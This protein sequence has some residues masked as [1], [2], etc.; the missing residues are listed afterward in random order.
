MEDRTLK[1]VDGMCGQLHQISAFGQERRLPRIRLL[2]V[3]LVIPICMVVVFAD[4]FFFGSAIRKSW[5]HFPVTGQRWWLLLFGLPHLIAGNMTML[6]REYLTYYRDKLLPAVVAYGGVS[7]AGAYGPAWLSNLVIIILSFYTVFHLLA[8]QAGLGL[9]MLARVERNAQVWRQL[10][11][12]GGLILFLVVY[13]HI[14]WPQ[15]SVASYN[16]VAIGMMIF[17]VLICALTVVTAKIQSA[18]IDLVACSYLWA[19]VVM[20]FAVVLFFSFGYVAI[21]FIIPR[22]IHD[23]TAYQIYFNHD[24][25]RNRSARHHLLYVSRYLSFFPFSVTLILAS[26]FIACL[27]QIFSHP[28]TVALVFWLTFIHYYAEGIVWRKPHLHRQHLVFS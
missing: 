22:V 3:Y 26:I 2:A 23:L 8:Q 14:Q 20:L 11:I 4:M 28:L 17:F 27:L 12:V 10:F 21:V 24:A 7:F 16:P 9:T 18:A 6:D 13:V 5:S 19:N 25:N 1:I 15:V